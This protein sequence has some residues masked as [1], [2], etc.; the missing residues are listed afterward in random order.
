MNKIRIRYVIIVLSTFL[1]CINGASQKDVDTC[2]LKSNYHYD[3]GDYDK[4]LLWIEKSI[5]K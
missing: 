2:L 5:S 3:K 1:L 4:A